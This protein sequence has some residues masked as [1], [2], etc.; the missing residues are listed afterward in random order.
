MPPAASS[1]CLSSLPA[2]WRALRSWRWL[3]LSGL[4]SIVIAVLIW[5]GWPA[6]EAWSVGLL[7]GIELTLFGA[8]LILVAFEA[9]KAR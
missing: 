1:C 5:I 4:A 7:A 6:N 2:S 9:R 8:A 3:A